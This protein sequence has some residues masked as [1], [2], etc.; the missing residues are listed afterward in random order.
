MSD[1]RHF[2]LFCPLKPTD[3]T[4]TMLVRKQMEM[5]VMSEYKYNICIDTPLGSRYGQMTLAECAG[6]LEGR[7][8]I[9]GQTTRLH[10]DRSEAGICRL[11]GELITLYRV[12]PFVAQ[13]ILT[14]LEISLTLQTQERRYGLSGTR[15]EGLADA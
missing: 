10:G 1:N 3:S 8:E 5:F 7:M 4:D 9:L 13:G 11:S 12:I 2:T 15:Q 14:P 6:V